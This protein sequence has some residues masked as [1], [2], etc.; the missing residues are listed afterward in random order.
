M[1]RATIKTDL[2]IAANEQFDK[3][4]KLIDSMSDEHK[5]LHSVAR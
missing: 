3:M 2:V 4:W 5:M 1:S